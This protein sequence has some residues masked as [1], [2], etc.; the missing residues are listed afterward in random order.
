MAVTVILVML[1]KGLPPLAVNWNLPIVTK[2][3]IS[4]A[5]EPVVSFMPL[6]T[7]PI[8]N[9]NSLYRQCSVLSAQVEGLGQGVAAGCGDGCRRVKYGN[10]ILILYQCRKIARK[11]I[12]R[13]SFFC[14]ES[15]WERR[16]NRFS[17]RP[18]GCWC[19]SCLAGCLYPLH[20][21]NG[22]DSDAVREKGTVE[23]VVT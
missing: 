3:V 4:Q 22:G 21:K 14:V 8:S 9:H 19:P 15:F 10:F 5:E 11:G 16:W 18:V 1:F 17:L 2:L 7:V 6:Y 20:L 12:R 13:V 23:V